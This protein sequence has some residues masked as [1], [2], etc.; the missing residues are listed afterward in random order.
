MILELLTYEKRKNY[1][2]ANFNCSNT[3]LNNFI[4]KTAA[5]SAAKDLARTYVLPAK[6]DPRKIVG[7]YT[8]T[9]ATV[10]YTQLNLDQF[11]RLPDLP[12]PVIKLA[13]FAVDT[14]FEGRG[15]GSAILYEA[16]K[17]ALKIIET[18][19]GIGM[20]IDAKDQ[21]AADFYIKRGATPFPDDNLRLIVS[22]KMLRQ[23]LAD[24]EE[25]KMQ[26]TAE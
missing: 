24:V 7:F 1:D 15:I 19:G 11:K 12:A 8:L 6:S 26:A 4:A 17:N 5:N 3:D 13:R 20:M 23:R 18:G 10:E 16:Y 14:S 9:L 25:E 2:R 22:T 21:K